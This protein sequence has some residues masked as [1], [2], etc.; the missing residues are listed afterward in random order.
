ME[1]P[2]GHTVGRE[3]G[4]K[5]GGQEMGREGRSNQLKTKTVVLGVHG[6]ELKQAH[7]NSTVFR[8]ISHKSVCVRVCDDLKVWVLVCM[9]YVCVDVRA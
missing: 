9:A 7:L 5:E 1:I 2:G 6:S 4:S 3:G 8:N